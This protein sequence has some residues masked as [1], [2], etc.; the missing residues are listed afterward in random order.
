MYLNRLYVSSDKKYVIAIVNQ[1]AT[2]L[3]MVE[4]RSIATFEK[5]I[6]H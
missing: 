6:Y 1:W 5:I 4:I 2:D 3:H